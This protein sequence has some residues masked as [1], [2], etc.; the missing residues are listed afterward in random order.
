[1]LP[2]DPSTGPR[3]LLISGTH[4][5]A[6]HISGL[7][8]AR[9][10]AELASA[11][12][13]CVLLCP[14]LPNARATGPL[15]LARDW[16][17]PLVV[18]AALPDAPAH[19]FGSLGTMVNI[20]RFGGNRVDLVRGLRTVGESLVAAFR[21][22]AL[23]C[24][25]GNLE[26]VVTTKALARRHGIPWLFDIKDN[27]DLYLPRALRPMLALRLRGWAALQANSRLHADAAKRWL[28]TRPEIV[29]SGVD[30]AFFER[31][32]ANSARPPYV[33][34]VGGLYF[35]DKVDQFV[36]G[37]A[38]YNRAAPAPLRIVHLGS[39]IAM[40]QRSAAR[41][42][43][44]VPVE[45]AGYVRP[46]EM[47]G[48]CQGAAAN[49]YIFHG[50]TFHH[51]TFEL[52]A[53]R[54]PVIAFGG[55]LPET[56]EQAERLGANLDRPSDLAGIVATLEA[57]IALPAG[58]IPTAADRFFTWPEQAAMVETAIGSIIRS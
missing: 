56:I 18:A 19:R 41:H 3:L 32:P 28:G 45:G 20:L 17:T 34:L 10:A 49:A 15:N 2:D 57:A 37:I 47:A 42:D 24:T 52:F 5:D 46:A 50:R 8:A 30:T 55:E 1:M 58:P 25:F 48:I 27:V 4:P 23:W 13:Q 31:Q 16:S 54:R 21:P 7:R 51:K 14:S 29:Y 36:D 53:C 38:A 43:G 6:A 39:Q 40:L 44:L 22:Q 9:I 11:G 26:T 33:T 35:P 12:Y